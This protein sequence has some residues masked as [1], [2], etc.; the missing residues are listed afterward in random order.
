MH[1]KQ[2]NYG[3]GIYTLAK[4]FNALN[5]TFACFFPNLRLVHKDVRTQN[6]DNNKDC[7]VA[8]MMA[9]VVWLAHCL[10]AQRPCVGGHSGE[11]EV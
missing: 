10:T 7:D 1:I 9:Q 2:E 4:R 3:D 11:Q 5:T 8:C 6:G